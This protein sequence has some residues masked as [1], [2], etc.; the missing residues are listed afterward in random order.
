VNLPYRKI[1]Q[2]TQAPIM[3]QRIMP[4]PIPILKKNPI[5][6]KVH[7]RITRAQK[8]RYVGGGLGMNKKLMNTARF[9]RNLAII[10]RDIFLGAVDFD[11][12]E[13]ALDA[14]VFGLELVEV[15]EGTFWAAGGV[16]ETA[17]VGGDG[18]GEGVVVGLAEEETAAWWWFE[19][20][21]CEEAAKTPTERQECVL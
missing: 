12:H 7:P 17:E 16:E 3:Q 14:E 13:P 4:I 5:K 11:A 19:E 10:S 1:L 9:Y 2:Q 20:F 21:G 6:L 18:P 8:H 15:E